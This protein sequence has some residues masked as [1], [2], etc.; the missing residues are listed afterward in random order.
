MT[1]S[2]EVLLIW[3]GAEILEQVPGVPGAGMSEAETLL[4]KPSQFHEFL[5]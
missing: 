5:C 2:R 1:T 3:E 4:H